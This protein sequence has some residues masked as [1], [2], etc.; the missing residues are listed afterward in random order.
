[1]VNLGFYEDEDDLIKVVD[2]LISLLDGSL[3]IIDPDQLNKI[4]ASKNNSATDNGGN[5]SNHQSQQINNSQLMNSSIKKDLEE[6]ALRMRRYKMNETNL[7]LMI[8]KNKIINILQRVLD[9]QND[10]RLTQFLTEFYK[11]DLEEPM[12]EGEISFVHKVN[13]A[14]NLDE[15]IKKDPEIAELKESIDDKVVSWMNTAFSDKKLDL[16]RI[17]LADFVC[18]LLDLIL[19]ENP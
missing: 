13:K 10:V 9:I 8:T 15:L 16:E 11:S 1:M 5:E 4:N 7:L 19:Y 2:P 18:V 14:I 3:D 6:E 17:S 12:S